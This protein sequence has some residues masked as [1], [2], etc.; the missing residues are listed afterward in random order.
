MCKY[1][2]FFDNKFIW[3]NIYKLDPNTSKKL[4]DVLLQSTGMI[5]LIWDTELEIMENEVC[6]HTKGFYVD[7]QNRK[8]NMC[9]KDI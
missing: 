6:A 4:E 7:F 2:D 9:H 1:N 8:C 5:D 3:N